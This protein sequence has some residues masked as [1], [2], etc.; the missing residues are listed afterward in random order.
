MDTNNKGNSKIRKTKLRRIRISASVLLMVSAI[1]AIAVVNSPLG[2]Y[3]ERFL[4]QYIH[5]QIGRFN[6]FSHHGEPLTM[7]QLIN[8]ALMA[9]FFF[10]VG[11]EIKRELIGGELS[12][13]RKAMLPV[14]A[15][16]GGMIIPIVVYAIFSPA[17]D[18][19][20]GVAIPMATDIAFSLGVLAMV[21][22]NVPVSLKIFLATLAI[23]DDIGGI[24]VI[25]IFYSSHIYP[26]FIL[27]ILLLLA[28]MYYAGRRGISS[29]AFYVSGFVLV[30]F[31]MLQSGIHATIAGVLVALVVP[32][33]PK[34]NLDRYLTDLKRTIAIFSNDKID[35]LSHSQI[36]VLKYV[37]K[38]SNQAI[39]PTQLLEQDMSSVVNYLI[40]PLFA[41]ANA[42]INFDGFSIQSFGGITFTIIIALVLG[43]LVGIF[44]FT[45]FFVKT[46]WLS[47]P[48]NLNF[49]H[50][51]GVALLGGIG[52]TVSLFIASLSFGGIENGAV[53]LNNARLG[54]LTASIIA[55]TLGYF[56]LRRVL[57]FS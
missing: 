18:A 6:L 12:N 51:F 49:K 22:K 56:Y 47:L 31:L 17:G 35:V 44:S 37:R 39:S 8:D 26:V 57:K 10:S 54:V 29:K 1:L 32:S 5:L 30:W 28:I 34:V 55:G 7:A 4:N 3:Y 36:S 23:V 2:E 33:K 52:F 24:L 41:F 9:V 50:I 13:P 46:G 19:M 14:I 53:L 45:W 16:C 25:A 42:G 15:A 40:L 48:A 21:G 43:K 27:I 20:R 11:L 38:E